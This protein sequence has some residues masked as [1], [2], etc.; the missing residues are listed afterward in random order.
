MTL[1]HTCHTNDEQC[2][3]GPTCPHR[4]C[5]N[6]AHL[7]PVTIGVNVLR[8]RGV[9]PRNAAVTQCPA[10]H[11]YSVTNTALRDGSRECRTC[12]RART[13]K[14]RGH[15]D[16]GRRSGQR[17]WSWRLIGGERITCASQPAHDGPHEGSGWTWDASGWFDKAAS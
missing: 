7:E 6:P 10:G 13:T 9:A 17:C 15:D 8:G 16:G 12:A 1:D 5:V 14:L 2:K 3:G 4:A 11:P